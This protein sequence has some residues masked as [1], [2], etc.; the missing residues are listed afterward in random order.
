MKLNIKIILNI[1][2][3]IKD[4]VFPIKKITNKFREI[5]SKEDL[6]NFIQERSAHVTQTTLYG[7]IKTRVGSRYAMMFEDE[8]FIKSINL[9]KWNIYMD[10]LTDCTF[11]VF[12]YLVDKKN[13]KQN[14][15]EEIFLKIIENEKK[16][17]L[18]EKLFE[19]SKLKFN[20][21]KQEI[22]W[23]KYH[24]DNPFKESGLSLYKWSPIA[25]NLKILDKIIVLNSIK[26]KW[27]L[28]ENE[29]KDLTKNL[30]FN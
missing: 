1:L 13:L 24:Q 18:E 17:G 3:D 11:Y 4:Y 19:D 15:A 10:A 29:F 16:N 26:L 8:V 22:D 27:N 6:K 7:Y 28:V 21:R 25:E 23:K 12:S 20:Q 30:F 5:N 2:S 14:D 9:A